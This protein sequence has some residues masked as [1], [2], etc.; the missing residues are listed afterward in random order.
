MDKKLKVLDAKRESLFIR[1]QLLYDCSLLV[2]SDSKKLTEFQVRYSS[3]E[4]TRKE[5]DEIINDINLTNLEINAKYTPSFQELNA[6]DELYCHIESVAKRLRTVNTNT[7]MT[8]NPSP[9]QQSA[10]SVPRLPKI[11][12][13]E[14]NGDHLNWPRFYETFKSLVHDNPRLDD[15]TRMH[16][17][18][19]KLTQRAL[20]VST[21]LLPTAENYP[22]LWNA[23][24]EKYEDKRTL[25]S[26]YLNQILDFKPIQSESV[27]SLNLFVEKV[28]SAIN[29]LL[30]LK[31]KDVLDFILV[32]V[33]LSKLD[34][35]TQKL[36]E[37]SASHAGDIPTY[38]QLSD[39][40]KEQIKILMRTSGNSKQASF[41]KSKV[42]SFATK[43]D[44]N[45]L[46]TKSITCVMCK[47]DNHRLYRCSKFQ[48]F[49]VNE[50]IQFVTNHALCFNCLSAGHR[51]VNCLHSG[52]CQKCKKRHHSLLHLENKVSTAK[53]NE[54]LSSKEQPTSE[55]IAE[56]SVG[57]PITLCSTFPKKSELRPSTVLLATVKVQAQSPN[58]IQHL[59]FLIDTASQCNFI[60][61]N[62]YQ[63]LGLRMDKAHTI[64]SGI[65]ESSRSVRGKAF[66]NFASRFDA[67][68]QYEMEVLVVDKITDKLPTCAIDSEVIEQFRNLKLADDT[69]YKCSEIDGL[70]G[71]ELTPHILKCLKFTSPELPTVWDSTLG[72]I[73]MGKVSVK[74]PETNLR[75]Y[76]CVNSTTNTEELL[77]KFWEIENVDFKSKPRSLEDTTCEE[78]Y[79]ST[80]ERDENGRYVVSLPFQKYP[81]ILGDSYENA[82]QRF[83]SL[84]K[85]FSHSTLLSEKY[86][87]VMQDY[88]EQKH[89]IPAV[90]GNNSIGYYIPHHG[91]VKVGSVSTPLRVVFDASAKT[92]LNVSLNDVLHTGEKLQ[93]NIFDILVNFRLCKYAMTA[94]IKQMYRQI[95]INPN[96]RIYQRVLWRFNKEEPL[97]IYEL[98]T[99]A[100][101]VKSSPYLALRTMQQ[102]AHDEKEKFPLASE[103]LSRDIYMDD[104]ISSIQNLEKAKILHAQLRGLCMA[105][106]FELVKWTSN[107]E[108]VLAEIP[109]EIQLSQSVKFGDDTSKVL[110]LEWQPSH[111]LLTFSL[112]LECR[113]CT[114]RNILS[115]I[116]RLWDPLG[117][118]APVTLY[119]KLLIK[120]LWILK[121]P[122]DDTPPTYLQEFW[123]KFQAELHLLSDFKVPRHIGMME[124]TNLSLLGFCDA[125]S[126]AYAAAVYVKVEF[127][128]FESQVFLLCAKSRVAPVKTLSIPRLELC[129]ALLLAKLLHSVQQIYSQRC[130]VEN[131]YCFS[132]SMVVLHWINNS[133][134]KWKVFVANRVTKIQEL[135][136]AA[137]WFYIESEN[138]PCDCA[139]R[140]L[141][142]KD[143][144]DHVLWLNGPTWL[145]TEE[146]SWLHKSFGILN[147]DVI[148]EE[149]KPQVFVSAV[150]EVANSIYSAML[151]CSSYSR[152]SRIIVYV[153]RF[154]KRL[155]VRVKINKSDLV[156]AEEYLIRAVQ[157]MHFSEELALLKKGKPCS[158][159]LRHLNPFLENNL[160]RIGGRLANAAISYDHQHPF[161][162][163]KKDHFT[164]LVIDYYHKLNLHAGPH[165]LLSLLR[166]RFW[167]LAGRNVVRQRL[168]T[169]NRCFRTRPRSM[170]P[171]MADLPA[172]RVTQ[173][174]PF[175]H[176]GVD[177]GGPFSITL[178]RHRGVKCQKAYLCLFVCMATRAVHL[179]CASDL[180]TDTFI[181][182]F[183]RFLARR[184]P[185]AVL[186]SDR[187]TNFVGAAKVL[188]DFVESSPFKNSLNEE[189]AHHR[190][191]WK[192]NPP[193]A[194][195]FGGIWEAN[196]KCVKTHLSKVIGEQL[197]TYE[198]FMTVL[199][200][201]EAIMNSRPLCWLSSD[202]T[203]PLALTPSHF[204]TLTPLQYLPAEDETQKPINRL[205]RKS[206]LD[207]IV[208]S[209][210]K[211]W[212]NEYL[213][214]L[215]ARQ[216]WN[217]TT[218]P[219]K[220][221]LLVIVAHDNL[222]VLK[223]P[224]GIIKEVFPGRDGI[225][226]VVSVKTKDGIYKRP[227]V[228]LCPLPTQ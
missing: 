79:S 136:P 19:S 225:I 8:V 217:T 152:L 190:I 213:S 66:L 210:W 55:N 11:D 14:F 71:A 162:I 153:L 26:T 52:V 211:R 224:I 72:F 63:R 216:K 158:S 6:F 93:T 83:Y 3:L 130:I 31:L 92:S 166:Q 181:A 24:I 64:V 35:Q 77:Q 68:V 148:S 41:S 207:K 109:K 228:K 177:Y 193:S 105:G 114:K 59:R 176:T 107:S 126:R 139:S 48:K 103:I 155:P 96:H 197:L 184:G 132:D 214:Q 30:K 161:L 180:S 94:D 173:A 221:D 91:V 54:N 226:R 168:R 202:P 27:T 45:T 134:H 160:I 15:V 12:L 143:F 21:G 97:K 85:R 174:K 73:V 167:I 121:I 188:A 220:P 9:V 169:C 29:A 164:D 150:E 40:V 131:I 110:G 133:P 4:K 101:G 149:I 49:S 227:V 43:A 25:A 5:F 36:F 112:K 205:T 47:S 115:T 60:T 170:T 201:I 81:P 187:G 70:I 123:A 198:E 102:L 74:I 159:K 117:I 57:L 145:K 88:L 89:M 138:N 194:P 44:N 116:A 100:F 223:W 34:V 2:D 119:A 175:L 163:P 147:D 128:R 69:F 203:E 122:W 154:C 124:N 137:K 192:F 84:E 191:D 222:P 151:R 80:V 22:I 200:Q 118:I 156:T 56:P 51:V 86:K 165:H 141:L 28:D 212:Q 39:F 120:E 204:L 16:Y 218:Y 98:N 146:D 33:S 142:P 199:A 75:A 1:V 95:Y 182:T 18:L 10:T 179:E 196:I 23:L 17:L 38:K 46:Q 37:R 76:C 111:D 125:S 67:E 129:G 127:D 42:H 172:P 215:Q 108:E 185:C 144:L 99:V 61:W 82:C 209:Y 178:T 171:L 7:M 87:E 186:Y 20:S 135:I 206:L 78:L 62:C 183:K 58:G 106:G 189:L 90:D 65:G 50:R 104:V 13:I 157:E 53:T 195:H 208:Q 140:G 32:T 219:V 113:K